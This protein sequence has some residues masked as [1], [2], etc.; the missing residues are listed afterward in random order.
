VVLARLTGRADVVEGV[1][2]ANRR[3]A[4]ESQAFG[5]FVNTLP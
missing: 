3:K 2:L 4:R 1:P 5:N